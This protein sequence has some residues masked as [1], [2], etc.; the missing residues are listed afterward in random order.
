MIQTFISFTYLFQTNYYTVPSSYEKLGTSNGLMSFFME[1][2][3]HIV[4]PF[5]FYSY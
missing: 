2:A 1:A 4:P 5:T 3:F